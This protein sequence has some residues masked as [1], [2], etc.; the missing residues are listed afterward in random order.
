MFRIDRLFNAGNP[1]PYAVGQLATTIGLVW[2]LFQ[3]Y[4]W[5][6][7][8]AAVVVQQITIG[9]GIS[10]GYHRYFCHNSFKILWKPLEKILIW[11]SIWTMGGSPTGFSIVHMAH[12]KFSDK[13]NDPH[14]AAMGWRQ[15]SAAHAYLT[16]EALSLTTRGMKKRIRKSSVDLIFYHKWFWVLSM[17]PPSIMA[18]ISLIYGSWEPLIFLWF[19]P[20]WMRFWCGP[21]SAWY[22]HRKTK[23]RRTENTNDDSVDTWL[24]A[25]AIWEGPHNYHHAHAGDWDFRAK[26]YDWDP[27]AWFLILFEKMG[28]VVLPKRKV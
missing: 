22:S 5:Y 1:Y 10:I 21:F 4:D 23:G 3:G 27:G 16:P 13:P 28:L 24:I 25:F 26:W 14:G 6:W 20:S 9:F 17:I 12:H 18:V 19:I 2:A 15:F 11:L 8:L 7:W